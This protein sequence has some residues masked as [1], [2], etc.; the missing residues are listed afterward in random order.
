MAIRQSV[1]LPLAFLLRLNH[2]VLLKLNKAALG[3]P[4]LQAAHTQHTLTDGCIQCRP[5]QK[6]QL[7][8]SNNKQTLATCSISAAVSDQRDSVYVLDVPV[9]PL[10]RDGVLMEQFRVPGFLS[11]LSGFFPLSFFQHKLLLSGFHLVP[12]PDGAGHMLP[13]SVTSAEWE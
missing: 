8:L 11:S 3:V 6:P 5:F 10:G 7:H 4:G 9:A 13:Q 2:S 12:V 1:V